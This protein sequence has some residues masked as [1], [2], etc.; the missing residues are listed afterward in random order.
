ME[1]NEKNWKECLNSLG[2]TERKNAQFGG[3]VVHDDKGIPCWTY[4][5]DEEKR[6]LYLFFSGAVYFKIHK[7]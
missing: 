1:Y 2:F 5:T 3:M 7:M 4:E 6:N